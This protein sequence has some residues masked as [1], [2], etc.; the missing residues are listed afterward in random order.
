[1]EIPSR[2]IRIDMPSQKL[3][4]VATF[5]DNDPVLDIFITYDHPNTGHTRPVVRRPNKRSFSQKHFEKELDAYIVQEAMSDLTDNRHTH[6][7]VE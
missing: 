5:I 6:D 2:I 3:K 4:L 7:W 1:M